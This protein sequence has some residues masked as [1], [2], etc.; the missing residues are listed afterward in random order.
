MF[1]IA[2]KMFLVVTIPVFLGMIIRKFATNF[3]QSIES[4][5]N[6]ISIILFMVVFLSIYF[7]EWENREKQSQ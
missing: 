5:I 3:I 2:L 6:K 4:L 1:S 7:S